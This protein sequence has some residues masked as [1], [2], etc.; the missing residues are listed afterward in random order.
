MS[1]CGHFGTNLH[2]QFLLH[3]LQPCKALFANAFETARFGSRFPN[4][5]AEKFYA[6]TCQL[7]GSGHYLFFGFGRAGAGYDDR[8]FFVLGVSGEVERSK[9]EFHIGEY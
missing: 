7:G 2:A 3:T 9:I 8:T 1:V 4:A 5:G 6:F